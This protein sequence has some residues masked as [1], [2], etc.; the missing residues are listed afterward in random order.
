M[1]LG[2]GRLVIILAL[3]AS[4][5]LVLSRG[6]DSA[7]PGAVQPS[8]GASGSPNPS[9]SVSP[10]ASVTPAAPT[11]EPNTTGV[12]FMALNGTSVTGAG[13]AAQKLLQDDGYAPV[14]DAADSPLK[15]VSTTTVYFRAGAQGDQNE[16]D[17]QYVNAHYFN[18]EAEVLKLDLSVFGD[19]VPRS[20]AIVVVVGADIAS[21]LVK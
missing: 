4:G 1:H 13:A 5:V 15:N 19:V 11:P 8:P 7:G 12:T 18:G 10:S 6:F 3:V 2:V 14:L 17:A 21:D 9:S 16:A 20:A